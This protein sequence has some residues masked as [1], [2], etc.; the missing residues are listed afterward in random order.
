MIFERDI[1]VENDPRAEIRMFWEDVLT[2]A[3]NG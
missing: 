3:R 2:A 1:R